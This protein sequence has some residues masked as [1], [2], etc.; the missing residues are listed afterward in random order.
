MMLCS[1]IAVNN[2]GFGNGVTATWI[3]TDMKPGDEKTFG[4]EEVRLAKEIGS[5]EADHTEITCNYN[6]IEES[7][8]TESDTDPN[9]NLDPDKMAKEMLITRCVYHD[10][11]CIDCLTG[12]KW[13]GYNYTSG[14]CAGTNLGQS[15]D[16]KI[17]D[18]NGDGKISFYDLKNDKLDNLPAVQN[19]PPFSFKMGVKFS[20]TAGNDFQ[21]DIF[22]LTMIFRL[23]QDASQ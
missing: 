11:V 12:I 14:V 4:L 6:V 21:G 22:D 23:N 7:P 13:S 10:I 5:I 2:E 17:E 1:I 19:S 3:A 15:N 18:K 20:E 16:W 8:Q 9:T